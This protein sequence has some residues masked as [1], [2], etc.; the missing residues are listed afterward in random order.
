MEYQAI[1]DASLTLDMTAIMV[2][3]CHDHQVPVPQALRILI[4][5]VELETQDL[6][7]ILLSPEHRHKHNTV[8]FGSETQGR[9]SISHYI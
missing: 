4:L 1:D 5:V 9:I 7:H 6:H 8:A 3:I 2:L